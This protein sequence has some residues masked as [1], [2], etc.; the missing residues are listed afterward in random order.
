MLF[1]E[2]DNNLKQSPAVRTDISGWRYKRENITI[3]SILT[4]TVKKTKAT[5]LIIIE[6]RNN[7]DDQK[8]K[9]GVFSWITS[10]FCGIHEIINNNLPPFDEIY[11]AI[12]LKLEMQK[13]LEF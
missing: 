1:R 13:E 8:F 7:F 12:S 6:Q 11:N 3:A 10:D 4:K 5:E 9:R 2:N